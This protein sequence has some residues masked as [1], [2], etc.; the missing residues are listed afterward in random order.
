VALEIILG[1][2]NWWNFL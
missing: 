1:T 2:K